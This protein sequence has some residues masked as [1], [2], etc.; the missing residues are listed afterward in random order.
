M[1]W[2]L[3]QQHPQDIAVSG[4]QG[5]A[6]VLGAPGRTLAAHV[7]SVTLLGSVPGV[8]VQ[9]SIEHPLNWPQRTVA[10]MWP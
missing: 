3:P 1:L 4:A 7:Q 2:N 9:R 5:G 6:G 10:S 8:R